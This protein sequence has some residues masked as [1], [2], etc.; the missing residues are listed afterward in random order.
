VIGGVVSS[1]GSS[2]TRRNRITSQR[3]TTAAAM[4]SIAQLS[5]QRSL[6]TIL[7]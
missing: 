2:K 7:P 3:N 6:R 1:V 4:I 5:I